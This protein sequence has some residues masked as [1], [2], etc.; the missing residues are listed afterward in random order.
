M[1]QSYELLNEAI[2]NTRNSRR[3]S[4]HPKK[5]KQHRYER[6]RIRSV[7]R[8]GDWCEDDSI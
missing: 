2:R 5:A 7:I 1:T 6:R 4:A 3:Y 8:L